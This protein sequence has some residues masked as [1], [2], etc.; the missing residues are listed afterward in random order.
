MGNGLN[1]FA[2]TGAWLHGN[3]YE[4][5]PGGDAYCS[6]PGDRVEMRFA[7]RKLRFTGC[8]D[9]QQGMA[10]VWI[11]GQEPTLIDFYS[12]DRAHTM[13]WESPELAPGEHTFHLVVSQK[14][15]PQSRYF[16]V[17]LAKVEIIS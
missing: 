2:Y 1:E 12:P 17:S 4:T 9:K 13:L 16:W 7:G 14:K 8:K 3:G 10:E 5:D 6:V 15:N 11:D